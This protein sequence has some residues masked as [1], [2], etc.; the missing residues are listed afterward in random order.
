MFLLDDII[1][2]DNLIRKRRQG[3]PS[4]PDIFKKP[5]KRFARNELSSFSAL[6]TDD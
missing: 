4:N 5:E 1:V 2:A 3:K 6:S